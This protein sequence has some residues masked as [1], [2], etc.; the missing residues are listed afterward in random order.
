MS[1]AARHPAYSE[2][3]HHWAKPKAALPCPQLL[4]GKKHNV[5][6]NARLQSHGLIRCGHR[7]GARQGECGTWIWIALV[8]SGWRYVAIVSKAEVAYMEHRHMSVDEALAFLG[9]EI[10]VEAR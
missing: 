7:P 6:T 8:P 2:R 1:A 9:A 3:P 4:S 10:P 5:H